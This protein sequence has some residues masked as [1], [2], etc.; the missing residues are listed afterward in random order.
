[1]VFVP[2][3][4]ACS[5]TQPFLAKDL[6]EGAYPLALANKIDFAVLR[7]DERIKSA[8]FAET[9]PIDRPPLKD[10]RHKFTLWRGTVSSP[11][12]FKFPWEYAFRE[13]ANLELMRTFASMFEQLQPKWSELETDQT[14][15]PAGFGLQFVGVGEAGWSLDQHGCLALAQLSR[16]GSEMEW[17]YVEAQVGDNQAPLPAGNVLPIN[18]LPTANKPSGFKKFS[19]TPKTRR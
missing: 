9:G 5:D 1:M 13:Q 12:V 19:M 2:I 6:L 11:H 18:P 8:Q 16:D 10:D 15:S 17:L 3:E 4:A 14:A 7:L